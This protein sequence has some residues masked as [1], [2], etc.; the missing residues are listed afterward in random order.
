MNT[1]IVFLLAVVHLVRAAAK[2]PQSLQ[3]KVWGAVI[4]TN[5]GDSTPEYWKERG[6]TS[7]GG[8]QLYNAGAAFADRYVRPTDDWSAV[9]NGISERA[10]NH[11]QLAITAQDDP[12]VV[13][14][15]LAF[16]QGL[17]PPFVESQGKNDT[18]SPDSW[19]DYP[20]RGYQYPQIYVPGADN[21]HHTEMAG[22]DG[23]RAL[24]EAW[25]N[26]LMTAEFNKTANETRAFYTNLQRYA[27]KGAFPDGPVSYR[28]ASQVWS[29]LK[30]QYPRDKTL[31]IAMSDEELVE[32]Q[33]LAGKFEWALNSQVGIPTDSGDIKGIHGGTLAWAIIQ[34]LQDN[35]DSWGK[36]NMMT[37]LFGDHRAMMAFASRSKLA[38]VHSPNFETLPNSGASFVF[39]LFSYADSDTQG[40]N[41]TKYP[42]E[43][44]LFVRF[45][46]RNETSNSGQN[47]DAYPLFGNSPSK[48]AIPFPEFIEE[49]KGIQVK[50]SEWC[51]A[52]D[53]FNVWCA[54][55]TN[56][57]GNARTGVSG[58][59]D[60]DADDSDIAG[61][62]A[63]FSK[64][65]VHP[66]KAGAVGAA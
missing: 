54:A 17:Y 50:P 66:L 48:M 35:S 58:P 60:D 16:M 49:L 4:Y 45:F 14:S 56:N 27:L 46:L 40:S 37:L 65:Q 24:D 23:C 2:S 30:H 21:K 39:E 55:F 32:A 5:V 31:R 1:L 57:K 11:R 42:A 53:S 51:T 64:K 28:L 59:N 6:L 12:A 13:G 47:L 61:P 3:A 10:I 22:Y 52:C 20:F 38:S 34:A 15:S 41:A 9:I 26:Y 33:S 8:Q 29:Y 44:D 36:S 62:D 19:A 63:C 25:S 43:E 7:L 18:S